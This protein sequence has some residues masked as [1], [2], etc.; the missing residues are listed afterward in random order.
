M[1]GSGFFCDFGIYQGRL[2][3]EPGQNIKLKLPPL[4]EKSF[5][6]KK[7]PYFSPVAFWFATDDKTQL[8]NQ[9]SLAFLNSKSL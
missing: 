8:N 5:A 1:I 6:D 7:N 9:I 4:R 2:F 3:L